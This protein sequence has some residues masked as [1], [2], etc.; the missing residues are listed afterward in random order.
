MKK[1]LTL[2]AVFALTAPVFAAKGLAQSYADVSYA[3]YSGD[4]YDYDGVSIDAVFGIFDYVSLRGVYTRGWIDSFP[5]DRDPQDDPDLDDFRVGLRPHYSFSKELDVYADLLFNWKKFRGDRSST[6]T[7]AVYAAGVRYLLLPKLEVILG[8]E[9]RGADVD[10]GF[11]TVGG[12]FKVNKYLG[13]SVK[14][15]QSTDDQDYFA[16]FRLFF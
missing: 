11:G 16:G 6:E 1:V 13:I 4:D 5:R 2:F 10:A 3:V 12:T 9:Y 7:G 14:T 15:N 8:G